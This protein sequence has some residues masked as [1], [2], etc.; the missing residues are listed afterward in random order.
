MVQRKRIWL[1]TMRLQVP[2][3]SLLSGLEIWRCLELWCRLRMGLRSCVAVAVVSAS[4]CSSNLTLGLGTSMCPR[5]SPKKQKKFNGGISL[6]EIFSGSL[7]FWQMVLSLHLSSLLLIASLFPFS[8]AT[9]FHSPP[10]SM[11]YAVHFK[12]L[13][14]DC[15]LIFWYLPWPP[16]PPPLLSTWL[17]P[18][19]TIAIFPV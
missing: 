8:S 16:P 13:G 10:T 2:S 14:H 3:L 7:D 11:H 5:C 18:I 6:F 15:L 17:I 1:G 12:F 9:F 4:G 19:N